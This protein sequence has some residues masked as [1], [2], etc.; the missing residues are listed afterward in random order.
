MP[1]CRNLESLYNSYQVVKIHWWYLTIMFHIGHVLQR[2]KL[3][4]SPLWQLYQPSSPKP[5]S[6]EWFWLIIQS[7]GDL[8]IFI[9]I[10]FGLQTVLSSCLTHLSLVQS[11]FSTWSPSPSKMTNLTT[12]Y[13]ERNRIFYPEELSWYLVRS[14]CQTSS[15]YFICCFH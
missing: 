2:I 1:G 14:A 8:I 9:N 15:P 11:Y 10:L 7:V 5:V 3:M 6:R 12:Q 4:F 13:Y